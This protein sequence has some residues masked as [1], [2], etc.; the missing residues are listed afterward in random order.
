MLSWPETLRAPLRDA[1]TS[2]PSDGVRRT[3]MDQGRK[4]RGDASAAPG[5]D[6][7][8]GKWKQT[9][10]E[11]FWDFWTAAKTEEFELDHWIY[12]PCAAA[13]ARAPQIGRR[14]I[15]YTV[16]FELEIMLPLAED[17]D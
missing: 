9:E 16:R 13:F 2:T 8:E 3:P 1:W 7:F 14:G 6:S 17:D 11:A 5:L 12:G 10:F 15:Y 4:A